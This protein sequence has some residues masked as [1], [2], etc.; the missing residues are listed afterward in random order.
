METDLKE[1]SKMGKLVMVYTITKMGTNS[2]EV[3]ILTKKWKMVYT[4]TKM[5]I[6]S[7]EVSILTEKRKMELFIGQTETDLKVNS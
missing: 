3:S 6:N 2:Q 4:I 1:I 7:Q 5:E